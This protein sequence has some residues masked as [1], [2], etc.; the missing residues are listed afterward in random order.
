MKNIIRLLIILAVFG[1]MVNPVLAMENPFGDS[2]VEPNLSQVQFA[3]E[4]QQAQII[5]NLS[6]SITLPLVTND[7]EEIVLNTLTYNISQEES[8]AGKKFKVFEN[9]FVF[10]I[11][12]ERINSSA[13]L[14]MKEIVLSPNSKMAPPKGFQ[15]ASKIYEYNFNTD[16]SQNLE[17]A[18]WLSIKYSDED[19]F[20]K[21][22]YYYDD[23][24]GE[25]VGIKGI[26]SNGAKKIIV[27]VS[28]PKAKVVILENIDIMTEGYASWYKYKG[29]NCAASPDYPKGTKLK[30][31]NL[32]NGKSVIVK[33]NDWGPDRSVHPNRVIDLDVVAFKKI[34]SKS[35]GLC[36]V[37]VETLTV[38]D[39]VK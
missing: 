12:K 27:N 11:D 14:E 6:Q 26:I 29:C 37:K 18:F 2:S 3:P 16:L 7:S 36:K 28:T 15:L 39:A 20:R 1:L 5:D 35:Q 22:I 38:E 10:Q 23:V 33:I 19:Y 25:W 8:F 32:K 9:N 24:K 21:N 17:K 4:N 34:A 30:V 31:T 13:A